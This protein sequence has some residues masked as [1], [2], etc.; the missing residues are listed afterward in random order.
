MSSL[1]AQLRPIP[2]PTTSFAGQTIIVTGS[3][4]GLGLEAARHFVRLG[5]A[6][7]IL[8]VRSIKKG[9]DAKASIEAS[10][11]RKN[12]IEVW[13][14]DM[15]NYES[16]KAFAKKCDSLDRLDVLVANAGVLRNTFEECEGTEVSIVVN[17]IGTFLLALNLLP[18]MRKSGGE[19]GLV[20]RLVVTTSILHENAKFL[21]QQE[22]SIFEAFKKKNKAY[23]AD[24][25]NTSKLLEVFLV[26]SIS[27]AMDKGAHARQQVIL[28]CVNPGLCHSELDKEI[29]GLTGFVITVAKALIARST[30]V[31]GRT[32]VHSAA[33]GI[34]SHGQYMSECKVKESSKFVRSNEG[35]SV[36]QRVHNELMRVLEEIQP[37]V[38]SNI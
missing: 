13:Q 20:P 25:Y 11:N 38:T 19:T 36:Q 37:G 9:E 6:R 22:S 28:N 30:E 27:A 29:K 2:L 32:L 12:V 35:A 4:T 16:I 3:S 33:A 21:E 17:V 18:I 15:S 34:D 23:L 1:A 5:A 8:A 14:V 24:R 7:V 31:G 10:T 26:R